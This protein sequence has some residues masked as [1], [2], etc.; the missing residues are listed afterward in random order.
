MQQ[1]LNSKK[2]WVLTVFLVAFALRLLGIGWGLPSTESV[3][4]LHPDEPLVVGAAQRLDPLGG[5]FTPGFYSYG[6]LYLTMVRATSGLADAIS[7]GDDSVYGASL[8]V[9]FGRLLNAAAGAGTA[10]IVVLTLLMLT[11]LVGAVVGGAAIAFAPG[12]VVHSRFATVDVMATFFV[13]LALYFAIRLAMQSDRPGRDAVLGGIA[14]GLA[15]GVKYNA[16]LALLAV[17]VGCWLLGAGRWRYLTAAAGC[18]IGAFLISTPGAVLESTQFL[19]DFT[20]ELGHTSTGHGLVFAGAS[21][22]FLYHIGNFIEGY[23]L[24]ALLGALAAIAAAIIRRR[25]WVVCALAFAIPYYILIGRAEVK[26]FRYTLPLFPPLA[27]G[28]GWLAGQAHARPDRRWRA[29]TATLGLALGAQL[30]WSARY[31]LWMSGADPRIEAARYVRARSDDATL[32]AVPAEPWFYSPTFYPTIA[33]PRWV[34]PERRQADMEA[35]RRPRVAWFNP[36]DDS[37]LPWSPAVL[38]LQPAYVSY[39]SFDLEGLVL[40]PAASYATEEVR[41]TSERARAFI[42]RLRREYTLVR[43][44]GGDGPRIHDLMYVRPTIA[45]WMR[46]PPSPKSPSNSSNS[47]ASSAAPAPTR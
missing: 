19:R 18:C 4:G 38:D 46:N 24:I 11:N 29:L 12:H 15:A 41:Q 1:W 10:A 3:Y 40:Q 2:F 36:A 28:M 23:G 33:A 25:T 8:K 26:F 43:I 21:S 27:I 34:P 16:G 6:T 30:A 37:R 5:D 35:A 42:E 9:A 14:A 39:S 31:T 17:L 13:A 44:Y 45:V 22:G 47:S 32:A 7:G 20:Y